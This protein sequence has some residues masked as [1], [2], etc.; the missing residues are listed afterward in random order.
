MK[1]LILLV[2]SLGYFKYA[3][4]FLPH[5][6]AVFFIKIFFET[7]PLKEKL[8]ALG[9]AWLT[10]DLVLIKTL[11]W[12]LF[13]FIFSGLCSTIVLVHLQKDQS[14]SMKR[15]STFLAHTLFFILSLTENLVL[16]TLPYM[17]PHLYPEVDCFTTDNQST[18]VWS[19]LILWFVGVIAQIIHYK[20]AHSWS[21]LNG[22]ELN[23]EFP[24]SK[25][26]R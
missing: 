19:V 11:F 24:W 18:A 6:G 7:S 2:S 17:A 10:K 14:A 5:W 12:D 16:V 9:L 8:T 26:N 23:H 15:Y 13:K 3:I 21:G 25:R 4:F 22:P 1:S 20:A